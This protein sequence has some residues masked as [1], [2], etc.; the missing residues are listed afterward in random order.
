MGE[1]D[2]DVWRV[3]V[4]GSRAKSLYDAMVAVAQVKPEWHGRLWRPLESEIALGTPVDNPAWARANFT[5]ITRSAAIVAV[6]GWEFSMPARRDMQVAVWCGL[7]LFEL[8]GTTKIVEL[9]VEEAKAILDRGLPQE[10]PS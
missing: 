7:Q 1:V 6:P 2:G 9:D 10:L 5:R 8:N 3:Y 4:T